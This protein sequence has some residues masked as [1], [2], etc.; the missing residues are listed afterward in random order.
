[1]KSRKTRN[2]M[3]GV[4]TRLL[5]LSLILLTTGPFSSYAENADLVMSADREADVLVVATAS[6]ADILDEEVEKTESDTILKT[7]TDGIL[8]IITAEPGVLPEGAYVKAKK[9]KA[10]TKIEKAIDKIEALENG[11]SEDADSTV[12]VKKIELIDVTIYD[13]DDNE[14]QPDVTAGNIKVSFF[15]ISIAEESGLSELSIYHF[16]D[17]VDSELTKEEAEVNGEALECETEHFST[18]AVASLAD[19]A[20]SD[21]ETPDTAVMVFD[22]EIWDDEEYD[23]TYPTITQ[24]LE[25][26][27][28]GTL[29]MQRSITENVTIPK[30]S[31]IK[32]DLNGFTL[33]N[34]SGH[35]ITNN[36]TLIIMDSLGDGK[37]DN[38]TNQK[39]AVYNNE[40]G[41]VTLKSGTF[42][43][44][45]EKSTSSMAGGENT[46]SVLVNH[47]D[48]NIYDDVTVTIDG[49]I[50][51]LILNGW[52]TSDENSTEK[53]ALL[54]IEGGVFS[55]GK[56]NIDNRYCGYVYIYGGT[57][58]E[59]ASD[60]ILNYNV[61]Q[62]ENGRFTTKSE[63][64]GTVLSNFKR[65]DDTCKGL[66]YVRNGDF[67]G[68]ILDE[69][70]TNITGG[71]FSNKVPS[72]AIPGGYTCELRNIGTASKY[73]VIKVQTSGDKPVYIGGSDS[74]KISSPTAEQALTS[75]TAQ[76]G[77]SSLKLL[78]SLYNG[79]VTEGIDGLL[80]AVNVDNMVQN[81]TTEISQKASLLQP[82][83]GITDAFKVNTFLSS[84]AGQSLL[85]G[86]AQRLS[87]SLKAQ[88][89]EM[90]L[91]VKPERKNNNIIASLVPK[92]MTFEVHPEVTA[93]DAGDNQVGEPVSLENDNSQYLNGSNIGF[94]LPVPSAVSENFVKV[95]HQSENGPTEVNYSRISESGNIKYTNVN[96]THFSTFVLEFV[97]SIPNENNNS[98]SDSDSDSDDSDMDSISGTAID[99]GNNGTWQQDARGWWFRRNDGSWPAREWL[100]C[101]WNGVSNWY[102]FNA[103]GYVDAGWFTDADGQ[104]YFLHDQHDGKFGYMYT[105]WNQIGGSWY[106]FNTETRDGRSKGSLFMNGT[107]PDGYEVGA[108]GVW[109]Q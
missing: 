89:T 63:K 20:S 43:R 79:D 72:S 60:S 2:T 94:S 54:N 102:Y 46:C 3:K 23:V 66:V 81:Y 74:M 12:K 91:T 80:S 57:F 6:D 11:A 4:A 39:A 26:I 47:G 65:N 45:D 67:T 95:T 19:D 106:Y 96:A 24:A 61:L 37:V 77:S 42:T 88:L 97:D 1:M 30:G 53:K 27:K 73:V 78:S 38:I 17:D 58:E 90:N 105:G 71:Y 108:D 28:K 50:S 7:E 56:E 100:E 109:V 82:V 15:N 16:E 13:A 8:V 103:E 9:I 92:K 83:S 22:V 104:R 107:T 64:N 59:G 84:A 36:G 101:V 52:K 93:S 85:D 34:M 10:S 31:E 62:I 25:V 18:F 99:V 44:S 21:K 32:L 69:G 76:Y 51:P 86:G 41:S 48:M 5:V 14:I 98:S 29:R 75:I 55:G 33:T 35:T 49:M 68:D 40:G 70:D 87:I